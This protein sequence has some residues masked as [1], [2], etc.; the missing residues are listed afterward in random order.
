MLTLLIVRDVSH[1]YPAGDIKR[2]CHV[3]TDDLLLLSS[4]STQSSCSSANDWCGGVDISQDGRIDL[5]GFS[6]VG[7]S[8][9]E[10]IDP[11]C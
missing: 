9:L 3:D 11:G 8:W 5:V 1:P 10:C 2:D 7:S 4:L 6:Y